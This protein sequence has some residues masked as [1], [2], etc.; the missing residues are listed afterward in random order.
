VVVS[1]HFKNMIV[2]LDHFLNFRVENKKYL[3]CHHQI[4][5]LSNIFQK[6]WAV[7]VDSTS[8]PFTSSWRREVTHCRQTTWPDTIWGCPPVA[9]VD[10]SEIPRISPPV[11]YGNPTKNGIHP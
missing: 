11:I 2:K 7:L 5:I 3:S 6:K 4:Y 9:T 8:P 10:A 1:T